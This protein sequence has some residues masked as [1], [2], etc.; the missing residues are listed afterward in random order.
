MMKEPESVA[1]FVDEL[2]G[3]RG[4]NKVLDALI[5]TIKN[6]IVQPPAE[7]DARHLIE[8]M[9]LALQA[10]ILLR[11]GHAAVADAFCATRLADR[12][13]FVYGG[14]GIHF[15]VDAVLARAMPKL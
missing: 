1:A 4:Q 2:E 7:R 15:D 14:S 5:D 11:R 10:S 6:R 13:G 9:A 8:Q 12:P 3:T